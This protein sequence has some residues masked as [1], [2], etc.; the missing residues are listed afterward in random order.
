MKKS[1]KGDK[2][3]ESGEESGGKIKGVLSL[4][5]TSVSINNGMLVLIIYF[6]CLTNTHMV[7]E[8]AFVHFSIVI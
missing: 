6:V 7:I 5:V 8:K 3:P 2:P 1:G 4:V